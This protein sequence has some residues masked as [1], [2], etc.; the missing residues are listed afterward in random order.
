[1]NIALVIWW[2][3][4]QVTI[5]KAQIHYHHIG[6]P[7]RLIELEIDIKKLTKIV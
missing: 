4:M 6:L 3:S 5:P 2:S 7:L 1:M